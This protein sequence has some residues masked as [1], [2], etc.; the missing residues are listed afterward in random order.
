MFS[1]AG[2]GANTWTIGDISGW[3]VSSVTAMNYMFSGAGASAANADWSIG[4]IS[5]WTVNISRPT[6]FVDAGRLAAEPNWR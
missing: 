3:I 2:Y 1:G 5:V 6:N 4:D